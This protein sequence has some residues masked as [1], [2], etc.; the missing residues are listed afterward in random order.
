MFNPVKKLKEYLKARHRKNIE[1]YI[2]LGY[3]WAWA[4]FVLGGM[5]LDSL[6]AY[7][8]GMETDDTAA[9]AFDHGIQLA[10]FD[11]VKQFGKVYSV[12]LSQQLKTEEEINVRSPQ[13]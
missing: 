13:A 2:K 12:D 7:A 10:L 11:M 5:S 6:N 4:E 3:G 9:K 1:T 8:A